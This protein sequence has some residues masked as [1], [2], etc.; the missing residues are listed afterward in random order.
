MYLYPTRHSRDFDET[1]ISSTDFR[2]I[3]K[4]C[5]NKIRPGGGFV[6]CSRTDGRYKD[7]SRF[8]FFRNFAN[9][10]ED[11]RHPN[12]ESYLVSTARNFPAE[13]SIISIGQTGSS[14]SFKPVDSRKT[15]R[16]P[17]QLQWRPFKVNVSPTFSSYTEISMPDG[18][19]CSVIV[20]GLFV[21]C[22]VRISSWY[23]GYLEWHFSCLL[24]YPKLQTGFCTSIRQPLHSLW[25]SQFFTLYFSYYRHCLTFLNRALWYT[26]AIITDRIQT[27]NFEVFHPRCVG[28]IT[29][30]FCVLHIQSN[31][32][33]YSDTSANEWLC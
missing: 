19:W 33:I 24:L 2:K 16:C 13:G 25:S 21:K 27:F 15:K 28:S 5:L 3:A 11:C 12:S 32:T 14:C 17:T 26:Y 31:T 1:W 9:E 6:P 30:N 8:F 7:D 20:L 18:N 23:T 10:P 4:S 22:Q 29:K